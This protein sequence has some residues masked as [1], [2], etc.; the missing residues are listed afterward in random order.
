[1]ARVCDAPGRALDLSSWH[2]HLTHIH[3][4]IPTTWSVIHAL[5][6]RQRA[7]LRPCPLRR[8]GG[9]NACDQESP[10]RSGHGAGGRSGRRHSVKRL[11]LPAGGPRADLGRARGGHAQAPGAAPPALRP[12]TR[13]HR[14]F[15]GAASPRRPVGRHCR[16]DPRALHRR[17]P[18]RA[19]GEIARVLRPGGQLL[20]I[21]HVRAES[22]ALARWQDRLLGPWR[23]FACG[24]RCNRAT[25]ELMRGCGFEVEAS[26]GAWRAMP[27]IVRPLMS[28]RAQPNG[29]DHG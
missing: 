4:A 7:D 16:V 8:R 23:R 5:G 28:G 2:V 9:R 27:P 22:P 21:E 29:L 12:S 11:A 15:G 19:L 14:S 13:D 1:M 17:A 26:K 18:D 10:G 24:C 20:F 25:V 3:A 6:A